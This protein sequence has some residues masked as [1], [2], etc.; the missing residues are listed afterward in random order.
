M[1]QRYKAEGNEEKK[2]NVVEYEGRP[3][4]LALTD[5]GPRDYRLTLP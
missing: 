5:C 4:Q 2:E 1:A 3:N